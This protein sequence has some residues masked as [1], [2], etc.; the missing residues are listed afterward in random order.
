MLKKIIPLVV[1]AAVLTACGG[2]ATPSTNLTLEMSDF[3]YDQTSITIPADQPV[4]ITLVNNGLVEHDFVIEKIDADV[5]LRQNGGTETHQMHGQEQEFDIHASAQTG[6]TT[7]L[8]I[9]VH[10]PGVYEIFCSVEGHKEA[11]MIAEL[12]VAPAAQ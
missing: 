11:G 8:E 12:I 5:V 7:I 9:T 1:L 3:A 4:Q 10:E 6:E 2:G